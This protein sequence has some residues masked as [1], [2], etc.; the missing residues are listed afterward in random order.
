MNHTKTTP[1]RTKSIA[2]A[3]MLMALAGNALA[4]KNSEMLDKLKKL[5][6]STTFTSVKESPLPNMFEVVMGENIAYVEPNG[7]YF[8]F[9]RLYDMPKQTDVTSA[10]LEEINKIDSSVFDIKDAIKLVKGNGARKL[11]VFSDPDCPFC[12]KLE[13][14]FKG[15]T[16][17]TIYTFMM[18]LE[19]IHPDAKR[20]AINVWCSKDQAGAWETLMIGNKEAPAATCDHPVDRILALARK[21]RVT[22]TP[23]MFAEDGRK[24]S[25]AVG[26]DRISAFLDAGKKDAPKVSQK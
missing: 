17:V 18:P 16:D 4:D 3:V 6:P 8:M 22:G 24:L 1:F 12:K 25:G 5:Y 10:R 23:T 9:G 15:L 21:L 14:D 7:R 2:A 11:Y 19:S 20:K 26:A 13:S